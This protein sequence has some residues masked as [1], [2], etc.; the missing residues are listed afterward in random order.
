MMKA[1]KIRTAI[2]M[3]LGLGP[4]NSKAS[5]VLSGIIHLPENNLIMCSS[6]AVLQF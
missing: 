3:V 1:I 6:Y 5:I 4:L 2:P